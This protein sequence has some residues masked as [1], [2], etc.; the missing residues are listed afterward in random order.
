MCFALCALWIIHRIFNTEVIKH[1][2]LEDF[3]DN[4]DTNGGNGSES[5]ACACQ[6]L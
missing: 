4:D 3:D 1:E 5:Q 6:L 2:D